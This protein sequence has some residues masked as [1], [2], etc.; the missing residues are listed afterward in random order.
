MKNNDCYLHSDGR[1]PFC[2]E[3]IH[4]TQMGQER[5]RRTLSLET[6]DVVPW[7]VERI[8]SPGAEAVRKGKNWYVTAGPYVF[9]VN[10]Y[11]CT[12]ITAHMKKRPSD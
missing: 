10:A 8:T 7:C 4:T 11:S 2:P 9:T 6:E 3:K 1:E 5:I 12:I